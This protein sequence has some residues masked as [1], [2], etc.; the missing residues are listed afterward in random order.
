MGLSRLGSIRESAPQ[1]GF[2]LVELLTTIAII[3]VLI[4]LMLPAVNFARE[5]SRRTTCSNNL[6]QIGIALHSYH[7]VHDS[8]PPGGI[9]WRP[10]GNTTNRQLAWSAFLLPYLEQQNVFVSLD[11]N[12]PFDSPINAE[13]AAVPLSVYRCPSSQHMDLRVD[14]RGR[15]DYGGIYGERINSRNNPPKGT[16]LYERTVA[17]RQVYDG[18]SQTIIVSEDTSWPDGQWI[19]GRN[20]FDQAFAINAAPDFE[21]DIR[22]E[23]PT[24][25]LALFVDGSVRFLQEDL[26]LAI[27]GAICTREGEENISGY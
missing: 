10:L 4:A 3:G 6:R 2:T 25:A 5:A 7:N 11:M 19:N 27:L 12:Q 16:M 13:G 20:I 15:C 24:G 22:S 1:R 26:E 23:H 17:V 9:E 21:N 8:F 14:G 18:T